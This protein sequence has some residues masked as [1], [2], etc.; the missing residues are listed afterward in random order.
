MVEHGRMTKADFPVEDVPAARLRVMPLHTITEVYGEAGLRR[1]FD[2]EVQDLAP[3]DRDTLADAADWAARLH[4]GQ[5]RTREPY[6]N[7]V[8]RVT[9]R[10]LCHYQVTDVDVLTAGLLHDAVEDQAWAVAGVPKH[11]TPPVEEALAAVAARVN[12][13]VARLV[14][15]VTLPDLPAGKDRIISYVEHLAAALAD[16]PWAR[17]IKLSD[18]TDNGVGIVHTVGPKVTRSARKYN[19]AL[20]VLRDLLERPDT[21][22]VAPVKEHIR[23]Q[24]DLGQ[25]RFAAILAA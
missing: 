12:P 17:V 7:H 25:R 6:L 11:G 13:R 3:A 10:M 21:P 14:R 8:L 9:L 16:E 5:R 18:F 20:P 19:A 2:L 15:A 1:R 22:L 4:A 23:E 24:L